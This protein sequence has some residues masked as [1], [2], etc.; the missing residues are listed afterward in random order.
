MYASA[1]GDNA[2]ERYATFLTSLELS[3]DIVERKL[4]LKRASEHSLDV[5]RV[6][7]ATA[8]KT[9]EKA[10]EVDSMKPPWRF[11][12]EFTLRTDPSVANH[13]PSFDSYERVR[14]T[15]PCIAG[16]AISCRVAASPV[17]RMDD[18]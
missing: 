17:D 5:A 3:V 2:I 12:S 9:I 1:L 4:A 14:S 8:E 6:A 10:F 15:G 11:P 7:V 13:P 16:A 18:V